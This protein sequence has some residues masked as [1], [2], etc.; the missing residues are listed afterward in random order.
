M[1]NDTNASVRVIPQ[2][3][4]GE[5]GDIARGISVQEQEAA[6]NSKA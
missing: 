5:Y 2:A 3:T 6:A 4:T 1:P